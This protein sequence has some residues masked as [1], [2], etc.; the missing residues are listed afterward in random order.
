MCTM[1]M[2]MDHYRD[3]WWPRVNPPWAP[4]APVGPFAPAP[5]VIPPGQ[6]WVPNPVTQEEV[7]EFRRLLDRARD[8]DRKN[9]EPDCELDEKRQT[10]K[11]LAE[12]MGVDISFIDKAP[13]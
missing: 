13:V 4:N 2:V 9:N 5:K 10:L 6:V 7:D 1:S 11:R 8:Y 12:Q 3:N